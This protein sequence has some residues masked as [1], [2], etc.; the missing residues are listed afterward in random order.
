MSATGAVRRFAQRLWVELL[1]RSGAL[2]YARRELSRQ[3]AIVVLALHRVL[4]DD[5]R[6]H[7]ASMPGMI[8][9]SRTFEAMTRYVAR[10]YE[11]ADALAD[12]PGR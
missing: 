3:G 4:D 11:T 1:L 12:K 2:W 7:T 8:V 9:R 10:Y 6:R 5:A